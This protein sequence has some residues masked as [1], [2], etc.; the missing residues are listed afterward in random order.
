MLLIYQNKNNV[1]YAIY[2]QKYL[3]KTCKFNCTNN[4]GQ[5]LL[6]GVM[7]INNSIA[8]FSSEEEY[9]AL[10]HNLSKLDHIKIFFK[11]KKRKIKIGIADKLRMIA[12]RL[13]KD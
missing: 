2:S 9:K 8:V 7:F 5:V 4:R 6:F 11:R 1:N 12:N 3:S 13:Y 10:L